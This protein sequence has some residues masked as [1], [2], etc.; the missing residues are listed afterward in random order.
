M[1][2]ALLSLVRGRFRHLAYDHQPG[3]WSHVYV[4]INS[5]IFSPTAFF[6]HFLLQVIQNEL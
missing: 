5:S 1:G 2:L 6:T 3:V 4:L